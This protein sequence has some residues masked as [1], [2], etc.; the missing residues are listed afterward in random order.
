MDRFGGVRKSCVQGKWAAVAECVAEGL[1]VFVGD[2]GGLGRKRS[3]IGTDWQRG[4]GMSKDQLRTTRCN[5]GYSELY[6][7]CHRPA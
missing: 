1:S 5:F 7:K 6:M 2:D 3:H 4:E